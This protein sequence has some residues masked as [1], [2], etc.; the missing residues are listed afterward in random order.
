MQQKFGV[1]A[2]LVVVVVAD[3]FVLCSMLFINGCGVV[4]VDDDDKWEVGS[5]VVAA[6]DNCWDDVVSIVLCILDVI[7]HWGYTKHTGT[8]TN[9]TD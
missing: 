3:V 9:F 7:S 5:N 4:I 2:D 1:F 8:H 6:T